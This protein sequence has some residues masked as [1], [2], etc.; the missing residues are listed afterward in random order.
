MGRPGPGCI[1][2]SQVGHVH[3]VRDLLPADLEF[4]WV[5]SGGQAPSP[6]QWA[7]APAL[8]QVLVR[9]HCPPTTGHCQGMEAR[10]LP[11]RDVDN[12]WMEKE[13]GECRL[14]ALALA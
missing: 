1:P 3:A 9:G 7:L 4:V 6:L 13:T 11:L 14:G 10:L 12:L 5:V 8:L 2:A